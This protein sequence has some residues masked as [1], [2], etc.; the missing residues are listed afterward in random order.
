[1][2]IDIQVNVVTIY[3]AYLR[4]DLL[5]IKYISNLQYIT[6]VMNEQSILVILIIGDLIYYTKMF[7][8]VSM[9]KSYVN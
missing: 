9:S 4:S 2:C 3:F 5:E 8:A 1:M 6:L 7:G